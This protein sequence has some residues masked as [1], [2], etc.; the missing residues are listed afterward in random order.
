MPEPNSR[1]IE[2][3]ENERSALNGMIAMAL[4]ANHD[5]QGVRDLIKEGLDGRITSA[6]FGQ[7]YLAFV[8]SQSPG[9]LNGDAGI[10]AGGGE[11]GSST[12]DFNEG[13]ADALLARAGVPVDKPHAA[14]RDFA[15][16]SVLDVARSCLI[17]A[18]RGDRGFGSETPSAII[19]AALSTSD[20]PYI[21]E[22]ALH[23]SIRVGMESVP[24]SHR[25]WCR[26]TH[27]KDFRA[28]SRVLLGS[29]PSLLPVVE[30]GEYTNGTMQEDRASLKVT[31]FGRII[32]LTLEAL[33]NDD[34]GA[35]LSIGPA[36]G[37]AALR[38]EAD[39]IYGLLTQ[40]GLDGVTMQ[41]GL[42][43]FHADH[44]NTVSVTS[45]GVLTSAALN[46]ARAKLRRAT[47]VGGQLLNL[48]PRTI[49]VPPERESEAES[50]VANALYHQGQNADTT[51]TWLRSLQV[52]ADP[53]LASTT[54]VYLVADSSM[55]DCGEVSILDNSPSIEEEDA[56]RVDQRSWKVRHSFAAG[57]LDYRGIIKLTLNS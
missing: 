17:R 1:E 41:D 32:S 56:F 45:A 18:G 54:T 33:V 29:A 8:A 23:K 51:A 27:A 52:V 16:M 7:R 19:K 57:F 3:A 11:R 2:A 44:A 26:L 6:V 21:L 55:I 49:V 38:T 50:L 48:A 53:R 14:A 36:L 42:P 13:V 30:G 37:L 47:G 24:I 4:D 43:L 28:Q 20:F 10:V 39:S 12:R 25:S 40:D 35:F 5:N 34:L 9:P 15:R 46:A 22:N 31:K